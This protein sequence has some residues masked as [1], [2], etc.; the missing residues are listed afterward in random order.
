MKVTF[1]G[2]GCC[3]ASADFDELFPISAVHALHLCMALMKEERSVFG[4]VRAAFPVLACVCAPARHP[5]D[6]VF[7]L[8]APDK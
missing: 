4:V 6:A 7:V 1:G 2:K 3:K 5:G 8:K